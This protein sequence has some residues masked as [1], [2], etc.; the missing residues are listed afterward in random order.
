MAFPSTNACASLLLTFGFVGTSCKH[1]TDPPPPGRTSSRASNETLPPGPL[2]DVGSR[3]QGQPEDKSSGGRLKLPGLRASRSSCV[4]PC[5]VMFS[6]DTIED[7]S[8]D[9]PF[10]HS[11]VSW[12]YDDPD[13][14]ARD[15]LIERGG[16]FFQT[17]EG[18]T[19][20]GD[21]NTPLGMHT[22]QCA[23]GICSS[24]IGRASC[25][26]RV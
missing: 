5:A 22:Y 6:I 11:G 2:P 16:R 13:A 12:D 7:S 26:E 19:R 3:P 20:T 23:E 10:A 1:E 9:N 14:D 21:T 25:R 17:K 15:G 18:A 24:Q 4:S 8:D